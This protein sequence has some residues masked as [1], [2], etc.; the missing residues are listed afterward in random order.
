ML[1]VVH[2]AMSLSNVAIV[3]GLF[4]SVLSITVAFR[5]YR[6]AY[7][8][9]GHAKYEAWS[10]VYR[11][12][13]AALTVPPT[14]EAFVELMDHVQLMSFAF[15]HGGVPTAVRKGLRCL[16]AD[17]I[18]RVGGNYLLAKAEYDEL[19]ADYY[20]DLIAVCRTANLR[21]ECMAGQSERFGLLG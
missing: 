19:F 10:I 15:R 14:R 16:I 17:F 7:L 5:V 21:P 18:C 4:S 1:H 13:L 6:V 2:E 11:R 12:Q 8:A 20:C 3:V 9:T